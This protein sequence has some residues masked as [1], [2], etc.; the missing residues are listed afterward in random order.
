MRFDL[1]T[2]YLDGDPSTATERLSAMMSAADCNATALEKVAAEGAAMF[3]A[4][5][6]HFDDLQYM[7]VVDGKVVRLAISNLDRRDKRSRRR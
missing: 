7:L 4:V 6:E 2:I 5:S 3:E 1:N